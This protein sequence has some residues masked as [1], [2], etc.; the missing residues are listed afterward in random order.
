MKL[1][2][3]RAFLTVLIYTLA[4]SLCNCDSE[5][6]ADPSALSDVEAEHRG[7]KTEPF[8]DR[9]ASFFGGGANDKKA[10]PVS[11]VYQRP[12]GG[13]QAQA[14][15]QRPVAVPRPTGS[16]YGAPSIS[17]YGAPTGSTYGAPP[18]PPPPQTP[19]RPPVRAPAPVS[20]SRA[21]IYQQPPAAASNN[22]PTYVSPASSGMCH[23]CFL[24]GIVSQK[25]SIS[26]KIL[27]AY[28]VY[29]S[30]FEFLCAYCLGLLFFLPLL[31]QLG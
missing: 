25:M 21:P 14:S 16:G 13:L 17:T 18:P 7:A 28:F 22:F 5:S 31:S 6:D 20:P 8:L 4:I 15:Q 29:I 24:W 3:S 27:Q 9:I 26:S 2:Y 1:N 11:P 30:V 10:K 12:S 23:C 19:V